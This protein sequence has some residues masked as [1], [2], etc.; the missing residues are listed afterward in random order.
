MKKELQMKTYSSIQVAA[1]GAALIALS[2]CVTYPVSKAV[3]QQAKPLTLAQV[4]ANPSAHNGTVVIWGGK[5]I[6][7]VNDANGGAVYVLQMPL[8]CCEQPQPY[9]V[10]AG[11]FIA[12]SKGLLDPALFK[13][14]TWVTI[15]GEITGTTTEPVQ[16]APYVYPVLAIKEV[17]VWHYVQTPCYSYPPWGWGWYGPYRGGYGCGPGWYNYGPSGCW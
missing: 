5:V 4:Q 1:L 14:G 2:G 3:R 6:Q 7:T 8:S 9:G 11:R 15:A 16:Q 12:R 10:P 17:H 13:E